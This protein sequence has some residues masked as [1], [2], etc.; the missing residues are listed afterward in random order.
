MAAIQIKAF[1]IFPF[2]PYIGQ[3]HYQWCDATKVANIYFW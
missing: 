3:Q 1:N 2:L